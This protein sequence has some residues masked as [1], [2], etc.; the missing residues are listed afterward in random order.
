MKKKTNWG[1]S[2]SQILAVATHNYF[3]SLGRRLY[4]KN[5]GLPLAALWPRLLDAPPASGLLQA[6]TPAGLLAN[7][8]LDMDLNDFTDAQ[9]REVS[10]TISMTNGSL[11]KVN[12]RSPKPPI[13]LSGWKLSFIILNRRFACLLMS[14]SAS[15]LM[16]DLKRLT[17]SN[18]C[19]FF[20]M[21]SFNFAPPS[22][23]TECSRLTKSST[24]W[25]WTV[26][27]KKIFW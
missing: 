26:L 22:R 24:M 21:N 13:S 14:L 15:S 17:F 23:K 27:Q 7:S 20:L 6:L 16:R 19:A 8:T 10:P 12:W 4:G 1:K 5:A 18:K 9:A 25:S 2:C 11:R 3:L